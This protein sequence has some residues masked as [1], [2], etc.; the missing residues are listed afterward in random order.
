MTVG[1]L[2][3]HEFSGVG[4]SR[5]TQQSAE[6]SSMEWN[7]IAANWTHWR[8]AVRE[9]WGKLTDDHLDLIAGRRER[10]AGRIRELYGLRRDEAERQLRNWERSHFGDTGGGENP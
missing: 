5:A 2:R 7:R 8:G 10:L 1:P 9:R 6:Y 4:R 3:S